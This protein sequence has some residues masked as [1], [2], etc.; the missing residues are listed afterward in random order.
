VKIKTININAAPVKNGNGYP[1]NSNANPPHRGPIT[2][3][4]ADND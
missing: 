2:L 4:R 3:A 1:R